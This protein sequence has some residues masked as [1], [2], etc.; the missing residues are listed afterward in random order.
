MRIIGLLLVALF[1]VSCGN[2]LD[3]TRIEENGYEVPAPSYIVVRVNEQTGET[4]YQLPSG[5]LSEDQI[6]SM[7]DRDTS[8]DRWTRMD[9]QKVIQGQFPSRTYDGSVSFMANTQDFEEPQQ[10]PRASRHRYPQ[11]F[12]NLAGG[13]GNCY[14]PNYG[15]SHMY[16]GYG[17]RYPGYER[18]NH[19]YPSTYGYYDY[20]YQP[21][22][23]WRNT[24]YY[25]HPFYYQRSYSL[26]GWF[27][28]FYRWWL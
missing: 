15:A 4:Q 13:Y 22:F 19:C 18:Y 6:I 27:Y 3:E 8:R 24:Y 26:Q 10:N 14:G 9:Q 12:S 23:Y 7:A 2:S 20:R 5:M 21:T 1:F 11:N 16:Y 17:Y 25:Y 28:F